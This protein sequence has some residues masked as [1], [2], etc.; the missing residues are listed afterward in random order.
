MSVAS[1]LSFDWP[2]VPT[3]VTLSMVKEAIYKRHGGT[4][5]SLVLYK[6]QVSACC[7]TSINATLVRRV[8]ILVIVQALRLPPAAGEA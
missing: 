7:S 3:D 6:D 1:P 8:F 2:A 4:V 5:M